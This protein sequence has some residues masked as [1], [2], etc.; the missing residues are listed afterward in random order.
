MELNSLALTTTVSGT[1]DEVRPRV[2][3]ALKA[4]G[5]S[6]LTE[7]DMQET[8]LEKLG[9]RIG[10]YTILGACNAPLAYAGLQAD[11]SIG[12]L[13]PCNVV[14]RSV[15]GGTQ[16]AAVDPVKLFD[17]L[18]EAVRARTLPVAEGARKALAAALFSLGNS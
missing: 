1:L 2:E 8:L 14:L 11:P 9:E 3:E 17:A 4:Q 7:I 16:V 12:L 18:P 6:V 5:F 13:M 15:T 10:P